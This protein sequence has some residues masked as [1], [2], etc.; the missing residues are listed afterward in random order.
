M[1]D[2]LFCKIAAGAVPATIVHEDD[3]AVGFEDID[4]QAP[5]HVLVIPRAHIESAAAI[6]EDSEALVGHLVAVAAKVA[7]ERGIATTGFRLVLNSGCDA[8]QAVDH[9]HV[10]VLGGRS[11]SWPPG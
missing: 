9:L 11:M 2:C 6:D 8:G 3:L 7:A 4:P 10:H 5:V 1:Q